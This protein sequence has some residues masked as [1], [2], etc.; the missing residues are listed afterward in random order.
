MGLQNQISNLIE[1]LKDLTL[2][3]LMRPHVWCTNCQVEGHHVTK[4]PCLRGLGPSSMPMGSTPTLHSVEVA[5][6]CSTIL[7]QGHS[8]Y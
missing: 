5:Q 3:L 8:Q 4:C 1:R 6:I 2:A 7:F